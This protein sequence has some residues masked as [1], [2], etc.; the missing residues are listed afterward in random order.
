MTKTLQKASSIHFLLDMD[1]VLANF[2]KAAHAAHDRDYKPESITEF[3]MAK[4]WGISPKE[5]WEP[6]N[7]Q[8]FWEGLEP[9]PW[10]NELYTGLKS[11]APVTI[12]TAPSGDPHCVPGK[13]AWLDKHLNVGIPDVIFANKK[14]LLAKPG[15]VLIDDSPAKVRAYIAEGGT[16]LIFPQHWNS[17]YRIAGLDGWK[18]TVGNA[19]LINTAKGSKAP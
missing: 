4:I 3:N 14:H 9:Y 11:I 5:F 2:C 13:L 6:L 16:A 18:A 12:C 15:N 17:G 10:A 19:R 1:G 7:G 8:A